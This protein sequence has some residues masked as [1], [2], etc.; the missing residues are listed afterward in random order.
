MTEEALRGR[1]RLSPL[2]MT[3]LLW[4]PGTWR[5]MR[6]GVTRALES[7]TVSSAPTR[8]PAGVTKATRDADVFDYTLH[9][10]RKT[11]MSRLTS[12]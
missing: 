4:E 5:R 7:S 11:I 12:G 1:V 8:S 6:K 9:G 10:G 2:A 3:Q